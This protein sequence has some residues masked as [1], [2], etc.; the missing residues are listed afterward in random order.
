MT[1]PA[2]EIGRAAHLPEQPGKAFGAFRRVG[3]Q[4]GAKSFCEIQQNRAGLEHPGRRR[5]AV[6]HQRRDLGVRVHPDKAAAELIAV[7]DSDQPG[8]VLGALVAQR[9]QLLQHHRNLHAVR[10]A[11][12]IELQRMPA[13]RQFF[14]VLRPG[15]RPVDA[16]ERT[17]VLLVP[18]P[19][20]RRRVCGRL[21]HDANS[22]PVAVDGH[23]LSRC[24]Q[25]YP[26]EVS[27][28][29]ME[30]LGVFVWF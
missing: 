18:G 29:R 21:G 2:A 23:G 28:R 25:R 16:R 22:V 20:F 11:E 30:G 24:Y 5:G 7:A 3:R 9:Q 8:V 13:D 17:P 12:R 4:E 27:V 15:G 10:C 1:E 26:Y 19:D 14:L 6:V